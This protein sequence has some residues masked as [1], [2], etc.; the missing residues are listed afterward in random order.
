MSDQ[1]DIIIADLDR[2]TQRE[3]IALGMNMAANLQE[4]PPTGT[5]VDTGWA[6]ANWIPSVGEPDQTDATKKE[7]SPA[8]VAA[9]AQ[10]Q[11]DGTNDVLS[12]TNDKGP[13]F[14][15]NNVPY[16]GA[17][18]AGH[19]KQSPSGFVQNA[20]ELAVRQ[21]YSA[22]ATQAQRARRAAAFRTAKPRP[23]R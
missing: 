7:P 2:F 16:I 1:I 21:T 20:L 5:P 6:R 13:I 8:D 15:A 22:G 9:A 14:V 18:D 17:L 4:E 11:Q 3:I 12:W 23:V 10:R 19:S